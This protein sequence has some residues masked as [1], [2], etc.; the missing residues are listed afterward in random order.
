MG[1]DVLLQFNPEGADYFDADYETVRRVFK[2]LVREGWLK[3]DVNDRRKLWLV[4][5][6]EWGETHKKFVASSGP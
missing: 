6:N 5:H 1:R 4:K 3:P 2:Q